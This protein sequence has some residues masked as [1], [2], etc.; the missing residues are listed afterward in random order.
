MSID[1]ARPTAG[2]LP[3]R[4]AVPWFTVLLLAAVMA[5]ADGF[6]MLSMRGATGAIERSDGAFTSWWRESTV[7]LPVFVVAVLGA[8]LLAIRLFGPVLRTFSAVA[9]GTLLVAMAGSVAGIAETLVSSAYDYYLQSSMLSMIET[10]HGLCTNS[11]LV[12]A[13]QSSLDLQVR[14][15]LYTS[16]LLLVTNVVLVGWLVAMRGGR[17]NVASPRSG[18]VVEAD[19]T[20]RRVHDVRLLVVVCLFG[21]AHL[22]AALIPGQLTGWPA[23]A[24][25]FLLLTAAQVAAAGLILAHPRRPALVAAAVVS[26]GPIILY[27]YSCAVGLPFGPGAGIPAPVS[28]PGCVACALEIATL[29][30][31]GWLLRAGPE[32]RRR[33]AAS[34]HLRG[35]VVAAVV[36]VTVIG[37]AGTAP[38]WFDQPGDTGSE[39]VMTH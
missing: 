12:Q 17:L 21:S 29:F 28:V 35:L 14:A 7:S 22:H 5:Y 16:G 36:A 27:L 31:V 4:L 6:W 39:T 30:A 38:S 18:P 1:S 23:A 8:L 10:M 2:R 34:A 20:V 15:A 11:C 37:I 19:D 26:G 33:P 13:Q 9:L 25:F 24:G 32:R 3:T